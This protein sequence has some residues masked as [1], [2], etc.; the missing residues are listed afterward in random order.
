[1]PV[2][3]LGASCLIFQLIFPFQNLTGEPVLSPFYTRQEWCSETSQSLRE[4]ALLALGPFSLLWLRS[5]SFERIHSCWSTAAWGHLP[6]SLRVPAGKAGWDYQGRSRFPAEQE[7]G[8]PG[9]GA[10]QIF[11]L[12]RSSSSQHVVLR[13]L[14]APGGLP[15]TLRAGSLVVW[16][17]KTEERML[18][19]HS[20]LEYKINY[21]FQRNSPYSKIKWLGYKDCGSG[22]LNYQLSAYLC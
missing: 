22:H 11:T 4:Q 20:N 8:S 14:T 1:M 3:I 18:Y 16:D 12:I 2:S 21:D 6:E 17:K 19:T 10:G 15:V 5:A 9:A 13:L 7:G